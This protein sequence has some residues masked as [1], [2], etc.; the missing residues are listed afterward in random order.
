MGQ[1][2]F[3]PYIDFPHTPNSM[4]PNVIYGVFLYYAGIQGYL[5]LDY[6]VSEPHRVWGSKGL[7]N[8]LFY[9][10]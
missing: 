5:A 7:R 1:I 3:S 9:F 4:D 10:V 2:K 8:C 6:C